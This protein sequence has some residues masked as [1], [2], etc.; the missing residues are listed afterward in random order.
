[1]YLFPT[2]FVLLAVSD[3]PNQIIIIYKEKIPSQPFFE[4]LNCNSSAERKHN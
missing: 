4:T 2:Y 1:M 3:K